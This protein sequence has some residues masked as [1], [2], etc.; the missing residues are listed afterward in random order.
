MSWA[1]LCL[2]QCPV[3][4]SNFF[5]SCKTDNKQPSPWPVFTKDLSFSRQCRFVARLGS[6]EEQRCFVVQTEPSSAWRLSGLHI[7]S[8]TFDSIGT[9]A[10]TSPPP[11]TGCSVRPPFSSSCKAA[12]GTLLSCCARSSLLCAASAATA[13]VSANLQPAAPHRRPGQPTDGRPQNGT[14]GETRLTG[15][16]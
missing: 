13:T 16:L 10:C 2:V 9:H 4:L 14:E 3:I 12:N 6:G 15:R 8:W 5:S 1:C 7:D 11:P